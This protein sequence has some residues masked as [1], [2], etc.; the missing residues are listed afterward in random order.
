[1]WRIKYESR[2]AGV[3]IYWIS[4][5]IISVFSFFC[6]TGGELVNWNY[7][8]YEVVL[9]FYCSIAVSEWVK[10]RSDPMFE[11]ILAQ[12]G[13]IFGWVLARYL[14][15]Y[16]VTGVFAV[17]GMLASS[18]AGTAMKPVE[19]LFVYL[20]TSFFL[21]SVGI[22]CSLLSRSAHVAATVCGV[23]WI[24][25]LLIKSMLRFPVFS[26]FYLFIRFADENN[27]VWW[28]NKCILVAA[29]VVVWLAIWTVC[30]KRIF[31]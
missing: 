30:R 7:L 8:G 10:T 13:S 2:I 9:V 3:N 28:I 15:V 5:L 6:I 23:V 25:F 17:F 18:L 31:F 12:T 19:I 1:M 4:A 26:Y 27:P 14:F 11:V 16:A 29:G 22:L 24:F 20:P 21:S